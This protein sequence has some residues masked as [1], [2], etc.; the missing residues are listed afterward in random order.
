MCW[1][2]SLSGQQL[3]LWTNRLMLLPDR[4]CQLGEQVVMP[5]TSPNTAVPASIAAGDIFR[6]N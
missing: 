4:M 3:G 2:P 1:L 5:E 6:S